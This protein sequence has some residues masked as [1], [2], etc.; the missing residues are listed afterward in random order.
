MAGINPNCMQHAIPL[1]AA[2]TALLTNSTAHCDTMDKQRAS[3]EH[4]GIQN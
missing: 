1:T 2:D 4:P 3:G